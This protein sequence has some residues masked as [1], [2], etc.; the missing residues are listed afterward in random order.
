MKKLLLHV[1]CAPCS[2]HAIELLK[3]NYIVTL[4]FSNSNIDPKEE[5]DKRL[6]NANI[7]AKLHNLT[8][9]E[10]QYNHKAWQASTKKYKDEPEKGKRCKICFN[11]SLRRTANYAKE[12]N[13][14]LFTTTLT[15]S[16][17]K[18]SKL[19]LELGNNYENFLNI[20][21][22]K[23]DGFKHSIELTKKHKLYRQNYCGCEYSKK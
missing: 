11:Y 1:C 4:F 12:H 13:Y 6:K 22:K 21:L 9:I 8:L 16:P 15:V 19:I 17:H 18:D 23:Q 3:K 14:D 20:N 2:T 10:D 7:I 5:Y